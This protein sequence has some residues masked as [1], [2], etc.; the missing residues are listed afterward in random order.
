MSNYT[1]II[2]VVTNLMLQQSVAQSNS[3][4]WI[5]DREQFWNILHNVLGRLDHGFATINYNTF[6]DLIAVALIYAR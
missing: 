6:I 1:G 4:Q 3:L 5:P 2:L